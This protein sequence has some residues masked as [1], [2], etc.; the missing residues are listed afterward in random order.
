ML[1]NFNISLMDA[2]KLAKLKLNKT[3]RNSHA[4]LQILL[5]AGCTFLPSQEAEQHS[6]HGLKLVYLSSRAT[7]GLNNYQATKLFL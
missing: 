5:P 3:Q 7:S 1:T 6:G 2:V 4:V